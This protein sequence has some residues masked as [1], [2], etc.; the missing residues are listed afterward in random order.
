M[1]E[2]SVNF[3]RA[4]DYYDATRGFPEHETANIIQ[5]IAES[6]KLKSS[7]TLLEIGIGTGRISLP[8]SCYVQQ[9]IGIDISHK[10]MK[11]FHEK[12]SDEAVFVALADAEVLPFADNSVDGVF[13]S[14]VFHLVRDQGAVMQ[15]LTRVIKPDGQ[16]LHCRTDRH[17][18]IGK[19]DNPVGK[20]TWQTHHEA[21]NADFALHGWRYDTVHEY[22][23]PVMETPYELLYAIG[24]RL[25]SAT[26]DLSD[27]QIQ[28]RLDAIRK[29]VDEH[30]D[31]DIHKQIESEIIISLE[32]LQAPA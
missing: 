27:E 30:F 2:Q 22:H 13:V 7:N 17:F 16:L 26:W 12:Q 23:C 1:R 24:N 10:M 21:L 20:S 25:W 15:E 4:A 14:H 32:I 18:G 6:A 28:S 11:K 19:L 31:G 9:I 8:L 3:D 29:G 5:F